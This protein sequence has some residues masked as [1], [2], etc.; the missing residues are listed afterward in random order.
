MLLWG[1]REERRPDNMQ[2]L[3]TVSPKVSR[4]SLLSQCLQGEAVTP[5]KASL[6]DTLNPEGKLPICKNVQITDSYWP[7]LDDIFLS[8]AKSAM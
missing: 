2:S 1:F 6:M 8:Q 3:A 5:G 4:R 7:R